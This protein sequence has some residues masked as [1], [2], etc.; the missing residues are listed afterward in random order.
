M[1]SASY[2]VINKFPLNVA[3][4]Y[5]PNKFMCIAEVAIVRPDADAEATAVMIAI[6]NMTYILEYLRL[7]GAF[8]DL[9]RIQG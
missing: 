5:E 7:L 4:I 9:R 6:A 2:F 3:T 8:A 1:K